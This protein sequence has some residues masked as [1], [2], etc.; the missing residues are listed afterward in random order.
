VGAFVLQ[1]WANVLQVP[2][3]LFGLHSDPLRDAHLCI[4]AIASRFWP[5]SLM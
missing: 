2:A 5:T 1:F 3:K 4:A